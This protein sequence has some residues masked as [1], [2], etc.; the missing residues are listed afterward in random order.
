MHG[1]IS[2]CHTLVIAR[3]SASVSVRTPSSAA[4]LAFDPA[5]SPTTTR[6]VRFETLSATR[7]PSRSASAFASGRDIGRAKVRD[8]IDSE[9]RRGARPITELAGEARARPMQ[10]RLPMQADKGDPL[11]GER[12]SFEERLDRRD[13]RVGH[14]ALELELRRLGLA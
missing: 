1:R 10:D 14:E 6:S 4:F 12:K 5:S 11:T 2:D 3:H 8:H 7:A 13:M 9:R